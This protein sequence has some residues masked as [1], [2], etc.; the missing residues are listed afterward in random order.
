MPVSRRFGRVLRHGYTTDSGLLTRMAEQEESAWREFDAKYRAMICAVGKKR[1]IAPEDS[2]DLVQEVM[3]ICCKRI[4][5]FFYDRSRG[6][7]RSFLVAIVQN[8][9]WQMLRRKKP[10]PDVP[11][12][13]YDASLD[14]EFMREYEQFLLDALLAQLRKRVGSSTYSAFDMLWLQEL[15]VEEVARITRKSRGALYLIRHR[16]LRILRESAAEIPEAVDRIHSRGSSARN[17]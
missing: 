2:E 11:V 10:L 4:G 9:A 3:L 13:E 16:C 12:P 1:G 7:F 17:A 8:I 14:L 15:P 5:S 6:H